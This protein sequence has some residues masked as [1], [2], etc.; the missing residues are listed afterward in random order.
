MTDYCVSDEL[1]TTYIIARRSK[2]CVPLSLASPSC[3][4]ALGK[5]WGWLCFPA[6]PDGSLQLLHTGSPTHHL[7]L[8]AEHTCHFLCSTGSSCYFGVIF[9]LLSLWCSFSHG[10]LWMKHY[11]EMSG[12]WQWTEDW[13]VWK[14]WSWGIQKWL[15]RER[16]VDKRWHGEKNEH[17]GTWESH[18][19]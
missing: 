18:R 10:Y 12:N 6:L 2:M 1:G 16:G 4:W 9:K 5:Y 17:Q 7:V 19:R 8:L 13:T 15:Q 3:L 14:I 11:G